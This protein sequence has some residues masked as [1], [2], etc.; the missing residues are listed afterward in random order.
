MGGAGVVASHALFLGLHG[1]NL[2]VFPI[3]FNDSFHIWNF[4]KWNLIPES[5]TEIVSMQTGA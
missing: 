1:L 4:K 5:V 2:F 3:L